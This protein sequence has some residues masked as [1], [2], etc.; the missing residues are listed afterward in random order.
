M[1]LVPFGEYVPLKSSWLQNFTPYKHDYSCTPG[2]DWTLFEVPAAVQPGRVYKFGMLICYEDGDPYLARQYNPS[3][4]R[5]LDADFL[6]NISNDGWFTGTEEHEQHLAI[7]RVRAVE[8]RRAI[9]RAVN[10]GISAIID[11]DGNVVA[12]P[13]PED[14]SKSKVTTAVVRGDVPIGDAPS[15][16]ARLGDWVPVACWC[17]ITGVLLWPSRLWRRPVPA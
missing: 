2:T 10:T 13:V 15:T 11:P 14:W 16:Y 12:L 17:F 6:V 8:S 5:G 4:G 1:H 7:C 3:A 9:V